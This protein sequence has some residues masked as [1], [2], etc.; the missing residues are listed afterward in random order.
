MWVTC[1]TAFATPVKGELWVP[2][3]EKAWAKIHG[4]YSSTRALFVSARSECDDQIAAAERHVAI[5]VA[6]C[7]TSH[8]TALIF[9]GTEY[10]NEVAAVELAV[11]IGIAKVAI[12]DR[13]DPKNAIITVDCSVV[14]DVEAGFRVACFECRA[15]LVHVHVI[16]GAVTV[17]VA[18]D[19][20]ATLH[21]MTRDCDRVK[22]NPAIRTTVRIIDVDAICL[23]VVCVRCKV[24]LRN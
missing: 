21:W 4:S 22:A 10:C 24:C 11:K 8:F 6:F 17:H 19:T 5:P 1:D 14:V 7:P 3:L 12:V 20:A 18:R 2:L 9:A 15:E 13:F 23:V 16:D